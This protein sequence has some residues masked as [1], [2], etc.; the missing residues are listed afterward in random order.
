MFVLYWCFTFIEYRY[1]K[2]YR[3]DSIKGMILSI[4]SNWKK[5]TSAH[6]Y[7]LAFKNALQFFNCFCLGPI[8]RPSKNFSPILC[9]WLQPSTSKNLPRTAMACLLY[10]HH[11]CYTCGFCGQSY[12][13]FIAMNVL[14]IYR[15]FQTAVWNGLSIAN[16]KCPVRALI[17]YTVAVHI[18]QTVLY[19]E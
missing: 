7:Y 16:K 1:R 18:V 2:K 12:K 4:V 14:I 17:P 8:W 19:L 10:K 6:P 13:I 11:G 9:W 15:P 3:I 5:T